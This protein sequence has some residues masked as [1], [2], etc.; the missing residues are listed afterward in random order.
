G[1]LGLKFTPANGFAGTATFD[2][3]AAT[4]GA[5]G[6]LGPAATASITVTKHATTTTLT[7]A[8][9]NPSD[10][11]QPITAVYSVASA[12]GGPAPNPA[13]TV[14]VSYNGGGE[15][16]TGTVAA[17][18]C[19]VGPS[20]AGSWLLTAHYHG[21]AI[22][23]ASTSATLPHDVNTCAI[24]PVVTLASDNG[25]PGTLRDA[26]ASVCTGNTI[27][28][29]IP[30]PGP[31]TIVLGGAPFEVTKNVTI[32]GSADG[33]VIDGNTYSR[34]FNVNPTVTATLDRLTLTHGAAG[35]GGA[36]SNLGTLTI[37]NSTLS[38]NAA[39]SSGGGV[40]IDV[41]AATTIVNSTI[42]GNSAGFAGGIDSEGAVTLTNVT[43]TGN[44][45]D[46]AGGIAVTGD[47]TIA[48][49]IIAGNSAP[50]EANVLGSFNA[51][52]PNITSGDPML[53]P[54]QNN[55]GPTFTHMPLAGSP[56][57]DAGDNAV[58]VAAGLTTDQ[59]GAGFARLLDAADADATQTV[60]LGAVEADPI[61]QVLA[62]Q[63]INEDTPLSLTV[64]V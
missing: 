23:A 11:T 52:G 39:S 57:L 49:S 36:V 15:T 27:T 44:T 13:S 7:S 55:G 16:C 33:I 3:Q 42:S 59:R 46:V 53:G 6:G 51:A 60:D 43:I 50:V 45:A 48:N 38:S 61:V 56:A 37:R 35:N 19:T 1:G 40:W 20:V 26:V 41:D 62:N 22:N 63:T 17:R 24:D 47:T 4:D 54:L 18:T 10:Q 5:G 14:T 32:S 9:P 58:A 21:D 30:G 34:I 2:V 8:D 28:F 25:D 12:D 29:A 31:H 64:N